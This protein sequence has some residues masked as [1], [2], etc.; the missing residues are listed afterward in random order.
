MAA[1]LAR[2]ANSVRGDDAHFEPSTGVPSTLPVLPVLPPPPGRRRALFLPS[3]GEAAASTGRRLVLFSTS[4]GLGRRAAMPNPFIATPETMLDDEAFPRCDNDVA[5]LLETASVPG[6]GRR[7]RPPEPR[8][9]GNP[10][11]HSRPLRLESEVRSVNNMMVTGMILIAICCV[12]LATQPDR[13]MGRRRSRRERERPAT[14]KEDPLPRHAL[15]APRRQ[16]SLGERSF[17]NFVH[18]NHWPRPDLD[19]TFGQASDAL[20]PELSVWPHNSPWLR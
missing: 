18:R 1:E 20:P 6:L 10:C 4:S 12:M 16:P 14:T 13:G 19:R 3:R 2:T 9:L 7:I 11:P 5:L 15:P 8:V 17:H